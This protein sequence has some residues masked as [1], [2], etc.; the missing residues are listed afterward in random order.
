MYNT[1]MAKLRRAT[2]NEDN[3]P[4][5]FACRKSNCYSVIKYKLNS[6]WHKI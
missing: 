3:I 4:D 5:M 6:S 1:Q 2:I